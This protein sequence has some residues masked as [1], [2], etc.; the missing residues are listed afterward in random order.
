MDN[1]V[2]RILKLIKSE[3]RGRKGRKHKDP[4]K[5]SELVGLIEDFYTEYQSLYA[6]F[7]HLRRES[8]SEYF[9]SE[10]FDSSNGRVENER[11]EEADRIRKELETAEFEITDLKQKLAST[12]Q[13]KEALNSDYMA[14]LSKIQEAEIINKNER[15]E[16]DK[17]E[18]ELLAIIKVREI[19]GNQASAR[20]KGLESQLTGLKV[21]VRS[22][23]GQKRDLEAQI[24]SKATEAKQEKEKNTGLHARISELELSL[25]EKDNK[26]CSLQE[27]L[28]DNEEYSMSKIAD[29]MA[30]AGNLQLEANSFHAQKAELEERNQ[31]MVCERNGALAQVK[32]LMDQVT[33]MQMEL[34][35]LHNQKS[36]SDQQ[37]E[38]ENKE[39]SK[40]PVVI[41]TLKDELV[42]MSMAE[43][44]MMDEKEGIHIQVKDLEL[45]VESLH[46]Q[47]NELEELINSKVC[48][49]NQL[50]EDKEGLQARNLELERALTEKEDKLSALQK[51]YEIKENEASTQVM[52][53]AQVNMLQDSDSLLNKKSQLEPQIEREKQESSKRPSQVSQNIKLFPQ[54]AERKM[55]ELAEAFCK[56][57]DDKTHLLYQ[58]ILVIERLHSESKD[59]YR[60]TKNRYEQEIGMLEE[61]VATYEAEIR[62]MSHTLET[63]NNA[64][65]GAEQVR[66][67]EEYNS[68]V[69]GRITNM[70]NELQ[71]AKDWV[72]VTNN[73]IKRL[74]HN[75]SCLA[76]QLE[77][78]EEQE[79][80]LRERVWKL[81]ARLSKEGGEK[82]NLMTAISQLEKKVGKL[83]KNIKEKD[84]ELISLG[85][86]KREAIRQL[87]LLIDYHRSRYDDLKELMQQMKK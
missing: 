37:M 16:V 52:N 2:T 21:E 25:K 22:L 5:E 10:E 69:A 72:T 63:T 56:N 27:K 67:F 78:K 42:R 75:E 82:L 39:T 28:K 80:I 33:A 55:E 79:F 9:S 7:D 23:C 47:K 18:K 40:Y 34:E 11:K 60:M 49:M 20:I 59:S 54:A 6:M 70:L 19:H 73:E 35:T 29:I 77:N 64:L 24:E 4:K 38:K 48:E 81:E 41:E 14:A 58:R 3:D 32:G 44:R 36:E 15:I 51:K 68:N 71:F 61:K 12:S 46:N 85:E 66:R 74:K 43:K 50:E 87:C 84:E 65:C 8:D 30:Q 76:A 31:K 17:R 57:L 26:V 86:E 45:E 62:K 83:E 1:H 53:L 13:E